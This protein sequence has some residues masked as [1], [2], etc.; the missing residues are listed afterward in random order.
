MKR[1]FKIEQKLNKIFISNENS[2]DENSVRLISNANEEGT[3]YI[4]K[5]N[6]TIVLFILFPSSRP[7]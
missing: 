7:S 1:I 4:H 6:D 5:V 3:Q 2:L